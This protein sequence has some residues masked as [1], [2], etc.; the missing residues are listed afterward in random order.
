MPSRFSKYK[1][2]L[3][4]TDGLKLYFAA[5]K[6]IKNIV[7]FNFLNYPVHFRGIYSDFAMFE[8][9]FIEKQ[10]E[11]PIELSAPSTIVD[12]GANV[13]YA[14]I[15]FANKFPSANI[16]SLEPEKNNF[17]TASENVQPYKNIQLELGAIWHISEPINVKDNGYGEAGFMVEKGNGENT[18]KAFTVQEIMNLMKVNAID[19]LKIDV[20][21]AEKE[22]FENN[23]ESW[24]P[25]TK[26]IIVETHD[27]YKKGTSKAIFNTIAKYNFSLELKGENLILIN[28]DLLQYPAK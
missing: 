7:T 12:L 23:Y 26:I 27:R 5:K 22:I 24:I 15:Y 8:Q 19:I 20:E 1:N 3:G 9:I 10:Y 28:N 25:K 16:F 2:A 6:Q 4:F 11:L 21:G 14:S 18:I 17:K 13:G